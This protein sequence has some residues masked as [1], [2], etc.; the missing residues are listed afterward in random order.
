[1]TNKTTGD[2]FNDY[3]VIDNTVNINRRQISMIMAI[4]I[5]IVL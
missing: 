5:L 4:I 2:S 1:M 3:E